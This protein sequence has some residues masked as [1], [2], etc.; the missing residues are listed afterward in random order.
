MAA[1][2]GGGGGGGALK[3]R[4]GT[5]PSGHTDGIRC[6][7]ISRDGSR[8]FTGSY[9]T[10]IRCWDTGTGRIIE[11]LNSTHKDWIISL[12]VSKNGSHLYS[13]D[14]KRNISI[15]ALNRKATKDATPCELT[16]KGAEGHLPC[17]A[18]DHDEST[19]FCG[20][21]LDNSIKVTD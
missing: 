8:M 12:F 11:T 19:L 14:A 3:Y 16:I 7:A 10:T 6:M 13:A 15:W 2:G 4:T 18:A 20:G 17:L 9:D 5:G 21:A 1:V